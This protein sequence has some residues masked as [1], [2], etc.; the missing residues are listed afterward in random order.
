MDYG[1]IFWIY[2]HT[3]SFCL[4]TLTD[5]VVWIIVMFYQLF[6]LSFW[7]HPFT[8]EHTLLSKWC[9][10]CNISPNLFPWW[11]NLTHLGWPEGFHFRV[12]CSFKCLALFRMLLKQKSSAAVIYHRCASIF[13]FVRVWCNVDPPWWLMLVMYAVWETWGW[14]SCVNNIRCWYWSEY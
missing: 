5:G 14:Q 7:R 1:L 9:N 4:K 10:T 12:N 11:N 2:I 13:S 8:A 3:L 6:G